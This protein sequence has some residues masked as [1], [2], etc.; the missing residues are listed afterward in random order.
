[1]RALRRAPYVKAAITYNM[2]DDRQYE[3][4][5]IDNV[6]RLKPAYAALRKAFRTKRLAPRR[7]KVRLARVGPTVVANISGPAG[8]NYQMDVSKNGRVAY[9]VAFR[10]DR[11]NRFRH[12][13]PGALGTRGLRARVW[14]YFLGGRGTSARV[15]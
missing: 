2:Q 13:L 14:Q 15:R 7:I 12:V 11:A 6:G 5:I 4:G 9:R 8:D 1:M 10:L 3:F